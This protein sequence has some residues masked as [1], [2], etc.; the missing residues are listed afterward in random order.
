MFFRKNTQN[1]REGFSEDTLR[2]AVSNLVSRRSLIM[3]D[4]GYFQL[5]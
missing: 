5:V 1:E 4:S 2:K 3:D